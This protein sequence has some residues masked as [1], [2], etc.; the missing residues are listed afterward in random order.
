MAQEMNQVDEFKQEIPEEFQ[1]E[2]DMLNA[3]ANET[4]IMTEA[5]P[6]DNLI[7]NRPVSNYLDPAAISL[8]KDQE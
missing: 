7:G 4:E 3:E 5:Q 1:D 6:P 2:Q 8:E